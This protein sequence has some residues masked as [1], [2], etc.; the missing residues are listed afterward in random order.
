ME[1]VSDAHDDGW[2]REWWEERDGMQRRA[3]MKGASCPALASHSCLPR[4]RDA[5]VISLKE[6][7][8]PA[9]PSTTLWGTGRPSLGF[10]HADWSQL[11]ASGGLSIPE[12]DHV[13]KAPSGWDPS[14]CSLEDHKTQ[15]P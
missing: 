14:L 3:R 4:L 6:G 5:P 10:A 2:E 15:E 8:P 9:W 7:E 11:D 13:D 1:I 12:L